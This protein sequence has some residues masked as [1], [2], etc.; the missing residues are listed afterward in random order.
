MCVC[1]CLFGGGVYVC[2]LFTN[3]FLLFVVIVAC[4]F[5]AGNDNR[6]SGR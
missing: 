4:V 2:V 3:K 1:M 6:E 5:T